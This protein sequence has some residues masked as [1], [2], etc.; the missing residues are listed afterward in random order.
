MKPFVNTIANLIADRIGLMPGKALY[1]AIEE[2]GGDDPGALAR[3]LE[4]SSESGAAWQAILRALMIGETYFFR[5]TAHLYWLR[6]TVLPELM[7]RGS[8]GVTLWSAGCATGEEVYSLALMLHQQLPPEQRSSIHLIGSDINRSALDTARRGLYRDWSFRHTDEAIRLRYFERVEGGFQI[9][10]II[11][12]MVTFTPNNLL[13]STPINNVDV[14]SCCNVLMYL[15]EKAIQ[16]VEDLFFD[17]LAPGGWLLLGQAENIRSRRE[18]WL[19]HLYPGGI[20]YQKPLQAAAGNRVVYHQGQPRRS[21]LPAAPAQPEPRPL[22]LYEEAVLLL[23]QE[24]ADQAEP[25]LRALLDA[26][27][28]DSRAHILLG[29]ILANRRQITD[30]HAELDAA[31]GENPLLA[32]AHYLKGMLYLDS[33]HTAAAQDAFRSALYCQHGHPLTAL[34]LGNI[35]A[36]MGDKTRARR[37]WTAAVEALTGSPDAPVSDL[38]DLTVSMMREVLQNQIDG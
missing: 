7:K 34:V 15:H 36:N 31:L 8:S 1:E 4:S 6:Q 32:D 17:A 26:Q 9:K 23:R 12:Q 22:T 10:S 5:Q 30:A 35:Y 3:T 18:R 13:M 2:V 25:I 24:R 28:D 37:V 16:R 38:N 27:P 20:A 33:G 29:Y 14:I 19:T 21:P 11:R